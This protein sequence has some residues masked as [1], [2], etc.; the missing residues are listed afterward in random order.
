M[1]SKEKSVLKSTEDKLSFIDLFFL[2]F[3]GQAPFISLLTFGTAMIAMV[4]LSGSFAML[5]ATTVVLFNGLVVYYLSKKFKRGGGYYVYAVYSLT[6]RLG[7]NTGW[8]YLIYALSYGGTLLAGGAYVLH[9][10]VKDLFGNTLFFPLSQQWFYALIACVVASSLVI[11]GV[12]V[13]A[14][15]AMIMSS[16]EMIAIAAL[17]VYFLYISGWKFYNPIPKSINSSLLDAVVLGLGI[18]TGYGSIAP[19]GEEA[20]SRDIGKAAIAVLLFGGL[21]ATFFFYSL[22]AIDFTG[23]LVQYLLSAFGILLA[24]PLAFIAL[25][26]GVLGGMSYILANSRTL[27]A[28]AEDKIF[29]QFLAIKRNGKP[30]YAEIAISVIFTA[31]IVLLTYYMGLYNAFV[32]LGSL[33]GMFNLFIHLSADFSLIRTSL[34]RLSKHKVEIIVGIVA[35]LISLFTMLYSIPGF[36]DYI[37]YTFMGWIILGFLYAEAREMMSEPEEEK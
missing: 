31:V 19:L 13:S 7:L 14:K 33:A 15:Y 6:P 4:G 3:G 9:F 8:T 36:S 29:P 20:T 17:A 30:L 28:M 1:S 12:K 21:L 11:A 27:K 2:S 32:I 18:P 35:V 10:I 16:I 23:N 22:G 5:I 34:K 37:V 26:D 25:N 24:L